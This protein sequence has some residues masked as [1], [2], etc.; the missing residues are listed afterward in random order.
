MSHQQVRGWIDRE[1]AGALP[2]RSRGPLHDHL[3]SCDACRDYYDR[4]VSAFRFMGGASD[5]SAIEF[6]MVE[7]WLLDVAPQ[8]ES[9]V[10]WWAR[11]WLALGTLAAVVLA[12]FVVIPRGQGPS[13][14]Q[15]T[16]KGGAASGGLALEVLCGDPL[17]PADEAGCRLD[18][19]MTFAYRVVAPGPVGSLALFGVDEHGDT[20]YYAPTPVAEDAFE[21]VL[22]RWRA[23]DHAV[24][25]GVN[26]EA[27]RMTVFALVT[28]NPL[29]VRDVD[30]LGAALAAA[31]PPSPGDPSWPLRVASENLTDSCDPESCLAAEFP[32]VL[33]EAER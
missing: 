1:L 17:R 12:L 5:P 30:R 27:G 14:A 13:L 31:G 16:A 8:A 2:K 23:V 9:K 24:D 22:G 18:E 3:R 26:H 28:K 32:L 19:T 10:A 29:T 21:A 25:L 4:G 7:G 11:P 15:L 33:H 20:L 6:D